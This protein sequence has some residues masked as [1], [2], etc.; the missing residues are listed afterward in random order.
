[1]RIIRHR[2]TAEVAEEH[3]GFKEAVFAVFV[4]AGLPT[5]AHY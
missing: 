5:E 1:M 2:W 4:V 3:R